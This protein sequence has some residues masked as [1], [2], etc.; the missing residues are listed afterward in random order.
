M[1]GFESDSRRLKMLARLGDDV[2]Y[3]PSGGAAV[4]IKAYIDLT[5][6]KF[7]IGTG[8][9]TGVQPMG[10][11]RTSDLTGTLDDEA[12][13]ILFEGITYLIK[14]P[15]PDGTGMTEFRLEEQ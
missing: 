3:T 9:V 14:A 5:A 10:E 4:T 15:T 1:P 8:M 6:D 11:A 2:V 13:T 12:D 7:D